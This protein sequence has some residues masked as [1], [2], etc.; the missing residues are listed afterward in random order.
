ME[1]LNLE[2]VGNLLKKARE[3]KLIS[4]KDASTAIEISEDTLINIENGTHYISAHS[5]INLAR[6][7]QI[8]VSSLVNQNKLFIE[9]SQLPN[10]QE[11]IEKIYT[12]FDEGEIT[13]SQF[14]KLLGVGIIQSRIIAEFLRA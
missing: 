3:E 7:Y 12:A 11:S 5:L 6:F 10:N 4:V 2:F 13:E 14:A 8:P 9:L 1:N